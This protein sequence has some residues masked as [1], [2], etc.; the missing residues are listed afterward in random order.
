MYYEVVRIIF[1][2]LAFDQDYI[3]YEA[4]YNIT[5]VTLYLTSRQLNNYIKNEEFS[6]DDKVMIFCVD[7]SMESYPEMFLKSG[8]AMWILDEEYFQSI[9]DNVMLRL[10]SEI[11]LFNSKV[12]IDSEVVRLKE[13]YQIQN[14]TIVKYLG[15][16]HKTYG[17]H[18]Y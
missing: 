8:Q 3:T 9:S 7:D 13:A 16:F 10:D 18:N 14:Q 11:I 12:L 15:S 2:Y 4:K 17:K 1:C 5:V 6:V